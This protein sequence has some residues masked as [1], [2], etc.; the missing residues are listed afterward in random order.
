MKVAAKN[1][2]RLHTRSSLFGFVFTQ[3][4]NLVRAVYKAQYHIANLVISLAVALQSPQQ[5]E[6]AGTGTKLDSAEN[7]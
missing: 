1:S 6:L 2:A 5:L 4:Y 3:L 7:L